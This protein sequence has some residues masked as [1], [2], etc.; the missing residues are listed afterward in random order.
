V[1]VFHP[2][3]SDPLGILSVMLCQQLSYLGG[4]HVR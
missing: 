1:S 4:S 2:V 3:S